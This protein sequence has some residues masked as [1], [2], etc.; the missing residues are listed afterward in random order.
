MCL[1]G[2]DCFSTLGYQPG[3]AALAA[4]LLSP[5]ATVV[6][7]IVTLFGALPVYRRVAEESPHG[8]GSIAMP[9]DDHR[10]R[11]GRTARRSV[12]QGLPGG[13]RSC[14][15]PGGAVA[16]RTARSASS[17]TSPAAPAGPASMSGEYPAPASGMR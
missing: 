9:A 7:V 4:G 1:T 3:I 2:V 8:E 6:L 16:S 13:D 5:V 11:A 17:P 15:R 12:P 10:A 14:R